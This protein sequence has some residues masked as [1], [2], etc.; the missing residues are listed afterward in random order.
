MSNIPNKA[1]FKNGILYNEIHGVINLATML[2]L[3]KLDKELIIQN[4]LKLVPSIHI[5]TDTSGEDFKIKP[6]EYGKLIIAGNILM[7]YSGIWV[8]GADNELREKSKIIQKL[9]FS[10]KLRWVDTLDQAEADIKANN[11]NG[12]ALLEL[13]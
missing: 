13:N 11:D 8:V 9:F 10:E 1:W 6:S 4:N 5:L 12:L 2:D 7:F 3:V